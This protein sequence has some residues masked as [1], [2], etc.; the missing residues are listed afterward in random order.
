M[1]YATRTSIG[2]EIPVAHV[3]Y[4]SRATGCEFPWRRYYC[5]RR[6][7]DRNFHWLLGQQRWGSP[8]LASGEP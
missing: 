6:F 3:L 1:T 8:T 5:S 2:T 4:R 7:R